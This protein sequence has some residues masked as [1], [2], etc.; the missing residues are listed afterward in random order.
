MKEQAVGC[1]I[2]A[3]GSAARFGANKLLAEFRGRSLIRLALEAVPA[4]VP[5]AVVTRYDEIEALAE[6]YGFFCVRNMHPELGVS[7][8]V[9]LGTAALAGRCAG[10]A[11]LTADQPLLRRETVERLLE[12]F[13]AN[14]ERI[15]CL[16]AS[17]VRGSPCVFP[18]DLFPALQQLEGDRGGSRLIRRFPER[19]LLVEADARELLDVD[20]AQELEALREKEG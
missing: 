2:L 17:G 11:F 10:L 20:T 12:T 15:V 13:R 6:E 16:A 4:G 14:P 18:A 5:A 3:A 19:V 9:R 1:V 8:S 7:H